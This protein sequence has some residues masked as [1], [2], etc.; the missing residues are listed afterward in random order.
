ADM[1]DSVSKT[2]GM[3]HNL[4]EFTVKA[5]GEEKELLILVTELTAGETSSR[6]IGMFGCED[7]NQYS[8]KLMVSK[9]REDIREAISKL[10]LV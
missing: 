7:Y 9:R 3:L 5:F 1:K 2:D 8:D 4:F 10:E 6:Y